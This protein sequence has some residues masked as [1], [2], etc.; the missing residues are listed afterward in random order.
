MRIG[1]GT[2][3]ILIIVASSV[4]YIHS[5]DYTPTSLTVAIYT[6]GVIGI[7]YNVEVDILAAKVTI[8]LFTS[9]FPDLLV[10]NQDGLPLV[11]TPID[12]SVIIDTLG[13]SKITIT[14]S[15]QE[16]TSKVGN[17][18]AFNVTSPTNL[19]VTLPSGATIVSMSQM[20]LDVSI[21]DGRTQVMMPPGDDSISYVISGV[22]TKE[23]AKSVIIDAEESL[24]TIKAKGVL[25]TEA[26]GLLAQANTA[27]NLGDYLKTEQLATQAK[28]SA[29]DAEIQAQAA[30]LAIQRA[31]T[32]IQ[33]ARNEGRNSNLAVAD[34]LVANAQSSYIAGD[35]TNAKTSADRAHDTAIKSESVSNNFLLV[36]VGI[37]ALLAITGGAIIY[38]RRGK[39]LSPP[40]PLAKEGDTSHVE[41]DM[42]FQK[43]PGLRVD[44]KEVLR[45]LTEHGGEAFAN[46]IRDRFDI[47]RTSA[48]R[49]IRRLIDAGIVNERKIGGQSLIYIDKKYRRESTREGH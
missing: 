7:E 19:V 21:V 49:M 12:S 25:T 13:A 35:Y 42:I 5:A 29:L 27:F 6:D 16:L 31:T 18:W 23:H 15:T 14:Y 36:T 43:N 34:V 2:L 28:S 8:P 10:V 38:K 1:L 17:L 44:D 33:T 47:P 39:K 9:S 24:T 4:P 46:E 26:D 48:W 30:N 22:G 40:H 45:F 20:P 3:L 41:L 32:A 37:V 11:M